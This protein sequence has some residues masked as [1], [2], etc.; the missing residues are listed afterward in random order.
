MSRIFSSLCL[1][2]IAA[3]CASHEHAAAPSRS[4]GAR[5]LSARFPA[6]KARLEIESGD[7][8]GSLEQLLQRVS[9]NTGLVFSCDQTARD[10][11][12]ATKLQLSTAVSIESAHVYPRIESLLVQHGVV[13]SSP[14]SAQPP[15][16]QVG[17]I[18]QPNGVPPTALTIELAELAFCREHPAVMVSVTLELP[19][20]DVRTLGNSLR[21]MTS[22]PNGDE[23]ILPVANTNSIMLNGTGGSVANLVELLQRVDIAAANGHDQR[24]V[25]AAE[26]ATL[27]K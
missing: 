3:A 5:E 12:R 20:L 10:R 11:L 24:E 19:H 23:G 1:S 18:S 25:L 16:V 26:A 22:N 17:G 14:T 21:G 9:Q 2:L 8:S 13:L 27:A 7:A 15:V 4:F 6:A